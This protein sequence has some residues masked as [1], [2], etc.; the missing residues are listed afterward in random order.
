M[1]RDGKGLN[2][3][4]LA[5]VNSQDARAL[6]L[7]R[8]REAMAVTGL[9]ASRLATA[10]GLAPSTLNRFLKNPATHPVPNT[11]TL[12]AIAAVARKHA[13]AEPAIDPEDRIQAKAMELAQAMRVNLSGPQMVRFARLMN[14]LGEVEPDAREHIIESMIA[15]I[16]N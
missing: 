1:R 16:R 7:A 12:A 3:Q 15:L 10:A 2:L 9:S 6:A 4:S 11:T 14:Q 13:K 8:I 5:M